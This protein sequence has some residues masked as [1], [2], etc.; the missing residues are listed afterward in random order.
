MASNM[1]SDCVT[2]VFTVDNGIFPDFGRRV[3]Q[4][5]FINEIDFFSADIV[6]VITLMKKM[7]KQLILMV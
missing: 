4:N 3:D 2:S 5:I 1:T 7:L 6:K